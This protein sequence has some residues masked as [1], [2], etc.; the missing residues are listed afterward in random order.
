MAREAGSPLGRSLLLRRG[1]S[2]CVLSFHYHCHCTDVSFTAVLGMNVFQHCL[3]RQ[4]ARV[5]NASFKVLDA[6]RMSAGTTHEG[7]TSIVSTDAVHCSYSVHDLFQ[8]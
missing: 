3:S 2:G 5:S 6:L 7:R 1:S 4:R 8:Y